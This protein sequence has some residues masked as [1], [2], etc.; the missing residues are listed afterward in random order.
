MS[1]KILITDLSHPIGR[2]IEHD[3]EREPC[4]LLAPLPDPLDFSSVKTYLKEQK[5][6]IIINTFGWRDQQVEQGAGDMVQAV[7]HLLAATEPLGIPSIHFSSYL[8]FGSDSK[9]AHS[10]KDAPAPLSALGKSFV[11]LEQLIESSGQRALVLR[12]GWVIA[13]QADNLFSRLIELIL[14]GTH[15]SLSNRLRGAPTLLSDVARV[16]IAM[17]KQ[18]SCGADSWGI[19]HYCSGDAVTEAEFGEELVQLLIQNKL[20][21]TDVNLAMQDQVS[22]MLPLSAVLGCRRI[23]DTFGVQARSWRPSLLP[24]VKQWLHDRSGIK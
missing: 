24:L 13:A 10:E 15:A 22:P 8:V 4:K 19:F 17:A 5:P 16:T 9:S 7:A 18:I 21:K 2:A 23:R 12:L 3:L 14:A 1:L 6:D 20:L 11:Q